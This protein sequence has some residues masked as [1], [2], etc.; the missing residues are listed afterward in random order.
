MRTID[1]SD[2]PQKVSEMWK[3]GERG[4]KGEEDEEEEGRGE[5][6]NEKERKRKR[7]QELGL[8]C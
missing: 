6:G 2:I 5:E 8:M 7:R 3:E 1:E 4:G